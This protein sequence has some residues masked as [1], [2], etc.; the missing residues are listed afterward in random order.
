VKQST[1]KKS[2]PEQAGIEQAAFRQLGD[3]DWD[4]WQGEHKATLV[5]V[6]RDGEILLINKKTGL[7]KGKVNGPGGKVDPGETPE[8]CAVRECREELSITVSNLE[9][10]GEH[11]IQFVGGYSIHVWVYRTRDFN[12]VPT[13]CLEAEPLWAPLDGIPYEQMWEDDQYWLPMVIRGE[14]FTT[15]WIFDDDHMLDYEIRSDGNNES[16]G[17]VADPKIWSNT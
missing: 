16:W 3:I 11:R 13:E 14:R 4:S 5:F 12:V 1:V 17:D 9:Y 6:I 2:V 8:A 7:G 15:R 10:C